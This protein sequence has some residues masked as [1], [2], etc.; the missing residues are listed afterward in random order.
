[1]QR[2]ILSFFTIILFLSLTGEASAQQKFI[3]IQEVTSNSGITAWLVEDH[4]VPVIAM[5]FAFLGA[6][7][8]QD[9]ADKQGLTQLASNTMDEGAGEI[10]SLDFQKELE[11]LAITLRFNASR[12]H[13]AG[14][15]KT[16]TRNKERAFDLLK[17][18]ITEPRFDAEPVQRMREA[19]LARIRRSLADPNWRAARIMNDKVF[20]GHPYAQNSGGTLQT[21]NAITREDLHNFA[22]TR[23][24]QDNLVLSVAGDISADE[25]KDKMDNIFG[26]LPPKASLKNIEDVVIQNNG[27]LI[28]HR[29]DIPQS[30]IQV[31]QSGI[32]RRAP[33]YHIAQVMNFILGS[34]GF[35][36]RLME[37]VR[38][39]RGLTYGIYSSFSNY[40]HTDLLSV[41]SSTKNESASEVLSLI[42]EEWSKMKAEPVKD[43]ELKAAKSYLIGSLPL[44]MTSTDKISK[45]LLGMRTEDL[46][47]DY[48]DQREKAIQAV[49]KEDIQAL[50]KRL[51][52]EDNFVTILVGSPT[53]VEPDQLIETLNN[54]E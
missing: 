35:G 2:I 20:E 54:A 11:D 3:N 31:I 34:S 37:E 12:D 42:R 8:A 6:G 39:K 17:L 49:T 5:N 29:R 25:L 16:L 1:M 24:A 26:D 47:I 4:S 38:E 46:P 15:L 50:A 48:L 32:S 7:A 45:L 21:L 18:A 41:S 19:N 51:L 22:K 43:E 14:N 44:A 36:S 40:N 28:L 27:Q 53:D 52:N 30:V 33:D 10:T 9:S 23:L 13:F